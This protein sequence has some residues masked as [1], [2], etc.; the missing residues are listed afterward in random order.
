MGLDANWSVAGVAPSRSK[1]LMVSVFTDSDVVG[2]QV[3]SRVL[4]TA[5][6]CRLVGTLMES[7]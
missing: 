1:I 3:I 7:K 6:D 5:I 2:S 4:P